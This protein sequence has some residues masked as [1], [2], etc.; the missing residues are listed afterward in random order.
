MNFPS[1]PSV[2]Q[3]NVP[4]TPLE[5]FDERVASGALTPDPYQRE[6]MVAL[7]RLYHDLATPRRKGFLGFGRKADTIRGVYLY[8]GVGRGKSMLMDLFFSTLA[9][10]KRRVHFHAFMLGIHE[11][12]NRARLEGRAD[13][14]LQDIAKQTAKDLRV[15]CFD[16]FHVTNV[17]DAM[18]LSRLF[19]FLFDHGL[20]IVMTSNWQ[21]HRLYED[22]LQR[23]RFLPF[24]DLVRDRMEIVQVDG[25]TDYRMKAM[26][27]TGV[28]FSP[29]NEASRVKASDLFEKLTVGAAPLA[30]VLHAQGREIHVTQAASGVAR[31]SFAQL[32]ERP[33]GAAD[34]LAIAEKYHT[35]F[36][37]GV[38]RLN[39]D[40]RNEAK[41][42]MTLIDVL[43]DNHIRLVMTADAPADQLYLGQDHA[44]EF[45]RTVSR[46][47]EMQGD[48]YLAC[49]PL[50]LKGEGR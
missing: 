12:L 13:H 44:F 11:E 29:L 43:Y 35:V 26:A 7:D 8:G 19:T 23:D 30:D 33:A 32:C 10:P 2:L 46:L 14:A 36:L 17:A 49:L 31:F 38:P 15:L 22:G 48:A 39:Y 16:E 5:I 9:V 1:S 34:Y 21:P 41:R 50:S 28:Y 37:D 3:K 27:E 24:I 18:I 42:L 47:I 25:P 4:Q 40:R 20:A 45:Q 6:G